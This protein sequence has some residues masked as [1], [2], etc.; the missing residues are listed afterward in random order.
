[1]RFKTNNPFKYFWLTISY[2]FDRDDSVLSK[3]FRYTM[4]HGMDEDKKEMVDCINKEL[5]NKL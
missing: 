1:M 3:E 4:N 2:I 5:N